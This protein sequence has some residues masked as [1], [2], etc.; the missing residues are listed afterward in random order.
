MNSPKTHPLNVS[1]LVAGL[2][3]LGFA[4]IWA[5][6]ESDVVDAGQLG[7]LFPLAL[8]AAGVVGLVAFAAKSLG[9]GRG[10]R[11]SPEDDLEVARLE[12]AA[13]APYE[14]DTERARLLE[15]EQTAQQPTQTDTEP[16]NGDRTEGETR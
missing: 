2:L 5:L 1:Y 11:P 15:R 12:A 4:V 8:V 7:W 10:R 13:Y 16:P 14:T 9:G 3:F 6:R